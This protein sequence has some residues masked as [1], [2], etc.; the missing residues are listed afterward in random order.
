[1]FD[2]SSQKLALYINNIAPVFLL[3]SRFFYEEKTDTFLKFVE[4][5]WVVSYVQRT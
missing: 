3:S 2:Q 4:F 5:L 1:M